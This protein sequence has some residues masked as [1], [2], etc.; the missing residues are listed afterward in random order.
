MLSE[1]CPPARGLL[2][3]VANTSLIRRVDAIP[4]DWVDTGTKEGNPADPVAPGYVEGV[5]IGKTR[6]VLT[7]LESHREDTRT[8]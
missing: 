8:R 6:R 2:R 7:S 3:R 1:R 4:A 5:S